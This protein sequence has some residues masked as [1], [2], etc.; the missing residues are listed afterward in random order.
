MRAISQEARGMW[1]MALPA[2]KADRMPIAMSLRVPRCMG[3]AV[4]EG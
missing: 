4:S 2:K 3:G 1:A